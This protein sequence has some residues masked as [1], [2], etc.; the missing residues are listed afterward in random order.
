MKQV[1]QCPLE[2]VGFDVRFSS[3]VV[4]NRWKVSAIDYSSMSM[5]NLVLE[6]VSH[7][8]QLPLWVVTAVI[9]DL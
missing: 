1:M 5:K 2:M 3:W 4:Q 9:A 7:R 8:W 6:C